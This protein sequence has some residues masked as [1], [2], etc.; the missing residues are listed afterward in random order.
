MLSQRHVICSREGHGFSR[1]DKPRTTRASA[2]EAML[3]V[4]PFLKPSL[5]ISRTSLYSASL[6]ETSIESKD[7]N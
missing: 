7:H 3:L 2:R 5:D 4:F 1:A 6:I